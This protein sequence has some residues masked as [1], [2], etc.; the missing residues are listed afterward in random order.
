MKLGE[1]LLKCMAKK[2]EPSAMVDI[3]CK[4]Y[5]LTLKTDSEGNAI[6]AFVGKRNSERLIKG[7]RYLRTLKYDR[8]G[9]PIKDHWDRKGPAS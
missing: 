9:K 4:G 3:K 2:Y 5:D 7:D 8:D 1:A 6:Q